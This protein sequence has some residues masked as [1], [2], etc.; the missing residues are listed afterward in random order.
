MS[1][2]PK[3]RTRFTPFPIQNYRSAKMLSNLHSWSF[4]FN[5]WFCSQ[6]FRWFQ[7]CECQNPR[8]CKSLLSAKKRHFTLA[9]NL[10]HTEP[11]SVITGDHLSLRL[12]VSV[13]ES[14]KGSVADE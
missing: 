12:V 4:D 6:Y 13:E 7:L 8:I 14:R 11:Y 2:I 10:P 3:H 9:L 1:N 5:Y